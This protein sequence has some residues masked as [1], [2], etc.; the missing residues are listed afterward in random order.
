MRK[1]IL[2]AAVDKLQAVTSNFY[3]SGISGLWN[4]PFNQA[5]FANYDTNSAIS[6]QKLVVPAA[7]LVAATGQVVPSFLE[8]SLNQGE[9][10]ST[11][12]SIDTFNSTT[13]NWQVVY[14]QYSGVE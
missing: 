6:I 14:T 4:E 8:I 2:K 1:D 12:F 10:N 11:N 3:Q 13:A 5:C 7:T 9:I